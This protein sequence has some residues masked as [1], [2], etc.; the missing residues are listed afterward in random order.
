MI[1]PQVVE[2]ITKQQKK[3]KFLQKGVAKIFKMPIIRR[4]QRR[5]VVEIER[6]TSRRCFLLFNN[7]SDNLCGHLLIL[8]K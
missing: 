8:E 7:Q 4:T 2:R 5:D 3:E 6:Y 1:N